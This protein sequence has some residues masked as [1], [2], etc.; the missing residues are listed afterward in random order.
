[1]GWLLCR[2]RRRLCYAWLRGSV[3]WVRAPFANSSVEMGLVHGAVSKVVIVRVREIQI[4]E[5][6]VLVQMQ[7]LDKVVGNAMGRMLLQAL[8]PIAEKVGVAEHSLECMDKI[9]ATFHV[10][11]EVVR[12]E[13]ACAMPL[14]GDPLQAWDPW[15]LFVGLTKEATVAQRRNATPHVG[16]DARQA[17][18]VREPREQRSVV[19]RSNGNS[20]TGVLSY[21]KGGGADAKLHVPC[22]SGVGKPCML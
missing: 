1:M 9:V 21:C 18:S 3:S 8:R 15:S 5:V 19:F 16:D 2:P 13:I 10:G 12:D 22:C 6:P 4:M 14:S 7:H 11:G 20:G 17:P